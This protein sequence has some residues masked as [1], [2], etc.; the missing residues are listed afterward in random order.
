MESILEDGEFVH[1]E[2]YQDLMLALKLSQTTYL[3][4]KMDKAPEDRLEMIR[5]Y[6]EACK[7]LIDKT[8][9]QE[10]N[11]NVPPSSLPAQA[12]DMPLPGAGAGPV[13]AEA[14]MLQASPGV[15]TA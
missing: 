2:P 9:S 5:R 14:A 3:Q 10:K 6:I 7:R 11:P 4:A 12:Q 1:P 15:A 13:S 8:M